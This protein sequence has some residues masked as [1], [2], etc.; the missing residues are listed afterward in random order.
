MKVTRGEKLLFDAQQSTVPEH[1][2][3][4]WGSADSCT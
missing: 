4:I 2:L 3:D 1:L